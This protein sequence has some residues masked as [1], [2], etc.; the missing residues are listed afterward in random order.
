[1]MMKPKIRAVFGIFTFLCLMTM[2]ICAANAYCQDPCACK[3]SDYGKGFRM[4]VSANPATVYAGS[5][6]LITIRMTVMVSPGGQ[7]P[8]SP[9]STTIC[10]NT[11]T[12]PLFVP[13]EGVR[14]F[15]AP[16]PGYG[17]GNVHGPWSVSAEEPGME[18]TD[19][20]GIAKIGIIPYAATSQ[21]VDCYADSWDLPHKGLLLFGIDD[22]NMENSHN[23]GFCNQQFPRGSTT[24][25]VQ[26]SGHG[27]FTGPSDFAVVFE[28][29]PAQIYPEQVAPVVIAVYYHGAPDAGRRVDLINDGGVIEPASGLTNASGMFAANFSS[30]QPGHFAIQAKSARFSENLNDSRM[31]DFEVLPPPPFYEAIFPS[32][33]NFVVI[34]PESIASIVQQKQPKARINSGDGIT[35]T[36]KIRDTGANDAEMQVIV[37]Q[38]TPELPGAFIHDPGVI[39][40]AIIPASANAPATVEVHMIENP[41][42]T[43]TPALP[44]EIVMNIPTTSIGGHAETVSPARLP[45]PAGSYRCSGMCTDLMT[46]SANCGACGLDCGEGRVCATGTCIVSI[47]GGQLGIVVPAGCSH[48][49]VS[50]DGNCVNVSIDQDNCGSCGDA[51]ISGVPCTNG[52][53]IVQMV[54]TAPTRLGG[55]GLKGF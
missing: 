36:G 13:A 27:T 6:T 51:C 17:P 47:P 24:I 15:I 10:K 29:S 31:V 9:G 11:G 3:P 4:Q 20:N 33:Y 55:V 18:W 12:S 7:Y 35:D 16:S 1:M 28:K 22:S 38:T 44:P 30:P 37:L 41:A 52:Q 32:L 49:E 39:P 23:G 48:G 5:E 50:C 8:C 40:P 45:C 54:T 46:D 26:P 42:L 53:C 2:I 14:V 21:R 19:K 43:P 34:I 25:D